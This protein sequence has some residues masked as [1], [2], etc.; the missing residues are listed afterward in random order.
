[1][2]TTLMLCETCGYDAAEPDAMRLG[3]RFASEVEALLK[4][5]DDLAIRR[6]RCLMA[7]QRH[8]TALLRAPGK[9]A[10]V[11]GGFRP[12]SESA[13]ALPDYARNYQLS[14]TGQVP[15][16]DWPVGIKGKFIAR[17]PVLDD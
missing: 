2:T 6:T 14:D 15:F 9:I 4:A 13:E 3:D 16:R 10:Y 12:N 1:M 17:I 7:C 5:D 8:C 11:L